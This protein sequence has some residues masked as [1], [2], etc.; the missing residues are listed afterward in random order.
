MGFSAVS[1]KDYI[2][3]A[4]CGDLGHT[5]TRC[6]L[7]EVCDTYGKSGHKKA[8]CPNKEAP[9]VCI[10]CGL[11]K[12]NCAEKRENCPTYNVMLDRLIQRIDYG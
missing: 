10:S 12:R 9:R 1:V 4:K 7:P 8:E 2:V 6:E 3:V 11:R 5:K